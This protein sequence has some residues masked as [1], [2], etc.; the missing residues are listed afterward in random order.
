D[1][2]ATVS[3]YTNGDTFDLRP[4]KLMGICVD[5]MADYCEPCGEY[6]KYR[7][8]DSNREKFG[9]GPVSRRLP[10]VDGIAGRKGSLAHFDLR[11]EACSGVGTALAGALEIRQLTDEDGL[12]ERHRRLKLEI[13]SQVVTHTGG[14][15]RCSMYIPQSAMVCEMRNFP[16]PEG[17]VYA[18]D[19]G[20][21]AAH[22]ASEVAEVAPVRPS[23]T[24]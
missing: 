21:G 11:I 16:V 12:T 6:V 13:V 1:G 10:L 20:G 18:P 7:C 15:P 8:N 3:E 19:P 24:N 2:F 14:C 23:A 5:L 17:F 9:Y 22:P 4:G